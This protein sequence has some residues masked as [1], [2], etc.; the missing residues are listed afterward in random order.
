MTKT[1]R[2]L[3]GIAFAAALAL[4][5]VATSVPAL[6]AVSQ[7]DTTA[8]VTK[9]PP[10]PPVR[11]TPAGGAGIATQGVTWEGVSWQ[12]VTASGISWE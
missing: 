6:A 7:G 12:G 8:Q 11:Q 9:K 5:L 4:S 2:T 3:T 1:K 10:K